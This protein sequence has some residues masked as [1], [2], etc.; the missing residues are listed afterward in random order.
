HHE[1][2]HGELLLTDIKY[3]LAVNPLRPAYRER[4]ASPTPSA[5]PLRWLPY[6]GGVRQTGHAGEDFAFDNEGP[7]HRVYLDG[8]RLASRLVTNGEYL[9]FMAAGGY[10]EPRYWLSDGWR[11]VQ[12]QGWSAPLYWE[13]V[14]GE[15]WSMTLV[16]MRPVVESEP[17]CHVSFYEGDAYARWAGKRLPMEAEWECAA[18]RV[19]VGGNLLEKDHL[20]PIP[21]AP[22]AR[23]PAQLFGDV[24]EWTASPYVSYPGFRP[25]PGAV[26]E[27]NGKFMCN[28][29]VLRGGSCATPGSHIRSSYRNFF[30]PEARW[31]FSGIRLADGA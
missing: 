20:H 26:G 12:E 3:N 25:A 17:V 31:Q 11:T 14:D 28:Q 24:W 16:G 4:T 22:D 10:R 13:Q 9:Q 19:P 23:E 21:A 27:Y 6:E 29:M 5:P 8:Y 18:E 2:Q 1:Q 30:P 15:W 7:R